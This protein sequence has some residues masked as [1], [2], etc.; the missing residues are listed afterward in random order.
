[1]T[2]VSLD[3]YRKGGAGA[4]KKA[5]PVPQQAIA[6]ESVEGKVLVNPALLR[7]HLEQYE[8]EFKDGIRSLAHMG[9]SVDT[10][11]ARYEPLDKAGEELLELLP[12]VRGGKD[13]VE[14]AYITPEQCAAQKKLFQ[15]LQALIKVV[16]QA[17]AWAVEWRRL[18]R[19]VETIGEEHSENRTLRPAQGVVPDDRLRAAI[20]YAE[21]P[22]A[23]TVRCARLIAT[24]SFAIAQARFDDLKTPI[25]ELNQTTEIFAALS[26]AITEGKLVEQLAP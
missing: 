1:M 12:E 19:L 9:I 14:V 6:P 3:K 2:V 7:G 20:A 11:K 24:A 8:S 17:Y 15:D 5:S 26:A 23:H 13:V 25:A 21:H 16:C 4:A 10:F 22:A 18:Q